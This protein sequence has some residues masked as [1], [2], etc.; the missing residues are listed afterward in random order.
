M[1]KMM[2]LLA[3]FTKFLDEE[4]NFNKTRIATLM[5][6]VNAIQDF[7]TGAKS[8]LRISRFSPQGSWAHKTIIRPPG[9]QGFDA[10][11]LV[12]VQPVTRLVR[13]S[14]RRQ[15]EGRIPGLGHVQGQGRAAHSLRPY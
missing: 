7:L 9:E 1:E 6:R 10:D 12:F 3:E 8:G 11:L 15:A 14:L 5:D 4:V 13:G 2:K